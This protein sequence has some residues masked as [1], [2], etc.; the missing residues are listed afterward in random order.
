MKNLQE[1]RKIVSHPP[2]GLAYMAICH[3]VVH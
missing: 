3:V 2:L 1:E